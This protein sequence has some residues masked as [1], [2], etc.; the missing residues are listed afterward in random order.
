MRIDTTNLDEKA[1]SSSP[2][3]SYSP[4]FYS[5]RAPSPSCGG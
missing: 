5:L 2:S 1:L 3:V 4:P